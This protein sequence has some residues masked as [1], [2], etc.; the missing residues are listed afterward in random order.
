MSKVKKRVNMT[1]GITALTMMM[2]STGV[3]A[4]PVAVIDS[5]SNKLTGIN[6]VEVTGYGTWDVT[7]NDVW[8]GD[9]YSIDFA[10]QSTTAIH[11]IFSPG[12][13]LSSSVFDVVPFHNIEACNNSNHCDTFTAYDDTHASDANPYLKGYFW[14][15]FTG[16]YPAAESPETASVYL[17]GIQTTLSSPALIHASWDNSQYVSAVPVPAAFWLFGSGIIGL[18]GVARRKG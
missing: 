12:G 5:L 15:N 11:D 18:I 13:F 7:F 6:A 8:Q 1:A 4:A 17:Q 2:L 16:D 3:Y 9:I 10:I 14:R